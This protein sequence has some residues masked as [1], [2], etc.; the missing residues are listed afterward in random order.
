MVNSEKAVER[1]IRWHRKK[2]QRQGARILRN[3]AYFSVGRND[4]R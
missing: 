2:I 3:A 1:S 4:E